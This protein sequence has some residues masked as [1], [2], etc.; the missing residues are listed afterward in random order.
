MAYDVQS[1]FIL[2][3]LRPSIADFFPFCLVYFL[4]FR[5][6]AR[7]YRRIDHSH[8]CQWFED[9]YGSSVVNLTERR[10]V[11]GLPFVAQQYH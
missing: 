10:S 6:N 2:S 7:S 9:E 5:W 8:L 3:P 4:V 11:R 1:S